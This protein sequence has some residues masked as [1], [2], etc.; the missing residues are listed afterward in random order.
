MT[1]SHMA[2]ARC[3]WLWSTRSHQPASQYRCLSCGY[4]SSASFIAW[5][6]GMEWDWLELASQSMINF[7]SGSAEARVAR[8]L[9]RSATC[10]VGSCEKNMRMIWPKANWGSAFT[11]RRKFSRPSWMCSISI[12]AMPFSKNACACG[13]LVEMCMPVGESWASAWNAKNANNAGISMR[14]LLDPICCSFTAAGGAL[15]Q[16]TARV[17][18]VAFEVISLLQRKLAIDFEHVDAP[19]NGVNV[20][21]SYRSGNRFHRFQQLFFRTHHNDAALVRCQQRFE[22]VRLHVVE[23]LD[24]GL[25]FRSG[26]IAQNKDHRPSV[27]PFVAI[28]F[29]HLGQLGCRHTA[30]VIGLVNDHSQLLGLRRSSQAYSQQKQDTNTASKAHDSAVYAEMGKTIRL[31]R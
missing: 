12:L 19:V 20:H 21:Q 29:E 5:M 11:E 7:S 8:A 30:R 28:K 17:W 26:G 27:R 4:F 3:D 22:F 18:L 6:A 1:C 14:S 15:P 23:L 10:S 24:G 2:T 13:D 25:H 31:L 16:R 9:S